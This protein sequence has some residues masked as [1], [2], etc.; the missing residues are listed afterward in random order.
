MR[1]EGRREGVRE[2]GRGKDGEIGGEKRRDHTVLDS[3]LSGLPRL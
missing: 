2:E 1:E 3:S